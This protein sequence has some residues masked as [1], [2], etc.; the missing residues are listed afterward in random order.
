MLLLLHKPYV[1][2]SWVKMY[3]FIRLPIRSGQARI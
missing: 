2:Y 1:V 3:L